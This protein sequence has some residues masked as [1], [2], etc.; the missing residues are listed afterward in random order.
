MGVVQSDLNTT[1]NQHWDDA[2]LSPRQN[3][4][5]ARV[6]LVDDEESVHQLVRNIFKKHA[7]DWVLDSYTESRKALKQIPQSPPDVVLMDIAMPGGTGIDCAKKL[8]AALP[9]LPIIMLSGHVD[10]E[11]LLHSM[12]AGSHGVLHK[13]ASA[14]D[15]I[16]ALHRAMAGSVTFCDRTEK[17]LLESFR[18]LGKNLKSADLTDREQEIMNMICQH[19][20][21]KAIADSLGIGSGTVHVHVSSIFKKLNVHTRADAV[22]KFMGGDRAK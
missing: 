18:H 19:K 1:G 16:T 13:P 14:P 22:R 7:P 20:T 5:P 8:K 17:T 2:V 9:H 4:Q 6:A 11:S 15:I 3:L 10:S 21:D 12:I